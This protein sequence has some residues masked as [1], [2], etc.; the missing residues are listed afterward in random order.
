MKH[1]SEQ[2]LDSLEDLL[3]HMRQLCALK[4]KKRG[5]FYLSSQAF[6]HF[7]ED[8]AGLFADLK[9]KNGWERFPVNT[10]SEKRDF[11]KAV[12]KVIGD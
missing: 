5:V 11:L 2:A 12:E 3:E 7:H 6:A 10:S 1:A 9:K 4:E 8:A